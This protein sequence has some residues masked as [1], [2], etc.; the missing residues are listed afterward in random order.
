[1]NKTQHAR[2]LHASGQ[3]DAAKRAYQDALRSSPDDIGLRRDFAVLLMQ[4]GSEAE[5][6]SLLDQSEVLAVADADL[7]S[8]LA[9]CLRATGQYQRALDV[10]R[11]TTTR[12]PR[13]ALGW[14]LLGSLMVSTGSAASAQE[15]L[16][17][18]LALEP[19]FGEAWHYLGE[20]LQALRQWDR[21]IYAYH[22]ASTQHPTEIIN[23]A[24]CQYLSGRMDMALRDFGAA[25]RMLPERTDILAQLAHCQAMLCQYDSEEK[26]VAALTTLLE[27]S[28]GH[29]PEPEPFLLS[30][31][32]VPETLKAESIRRYSQAILNEAQF[33]QP[34]AKA[35]KQPTGQRIRI[36]YLSADLGEHAI[37]TLVREHFAA[38]DR[39]RFEV[40]GYSLTGTRTLH[41]AIISGFDTLVDVSALDDDGLAKLIAH[42]CIDALIDMSGFTLGARP[43]VL[44]CRPARVQLGWLGFIHGQQAPWLDGLL[45][46]AHVQPAGKHW[47]YSD[48]PILLEG[49]LFPASTAHPGVRNR[50]RFG[51]PEDAPVLASFNNTYKL[52]SRLIGSWSKILTQADTAHLMVFAPPVACDGFLQQWKASG[53]PVERLHL[54]DKVELDEQA[55]RAASCDLFLDAFRY[56]AGATAIHAISNGLPL[57]CVEG[58]T[59]LARLGSGINRFLGMDQL[60]CRDVDEYVERAVRLAKSPILLSEQRQRLRRQAAV[61]HLFDPRR[62]AASIE[63]VVLQYLNQ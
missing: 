34:I 37:G 36:G 54:V 29:S 42:D 16:Q 26:S 27:A 63:A 25:H 23:I 57:L 5:A 30:T 1:M 2:E 14:M 55:D 18:A 44:A 10:S 32:A 47:N 58:P 21:A 17:R 15:P 61:H 6:A 60:V 20:S 39:N 49:T 3:L 59:P 45:L 40:F 11:E 7:L 24:L 52:C 53:G 62:A 38:H 4:S 13:N 12:D 9:L 35:P 19:H 56:Q 43:A 28:T 51:L 22:R 33:V 50:A 31:L 46:D 41:A 48:K 8:I